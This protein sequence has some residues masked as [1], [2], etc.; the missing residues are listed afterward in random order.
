MHNTGIIITVFLHRGST[1]WPLLAAGAPA[2]SEATPIAATSTGIADRASTTAMLRILAIAATISVR[3]REMQ[4][5]SLCP[6]RSRPTT[7]RPDAARPTV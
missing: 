3:G 1:G 2:W 5:A 6:I 4:R 7:I